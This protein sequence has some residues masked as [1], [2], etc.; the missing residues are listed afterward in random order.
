MFSIPSLSLFVR[1]SA[2]R[3]L[4]AYADW[5]IGAT[6]QEKRCYKPS[7]SI[8]L[9]FD[10]YG[11][12][13]EVDDLLQILHQKGVRAM[14]FPTG[15]WAAEHLELIK[16]IGDARHIIGNHTASHAALSALGDQEVEREITAGM[17]PGGFSPRRGR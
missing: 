11:T 16:K 8:L 9:T 7:D 15:T 14:F 3:L 2:S 10:D 13:A 1:H 6:E 17:P 4:H 12:A 5:R